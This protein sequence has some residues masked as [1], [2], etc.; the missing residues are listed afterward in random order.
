MLRKL[1]WQLPE[2][3]R[4]LGAGGAGALTDLVVLALCVEKLHLSP[5][6]GAVVGF[7]TGSVVGYVFYWAIVFPHVQERRHKRQFLLFLFTCVMG[8]L[9]TELG[10]YLFTILLHIHYIAVKILI[11][12]AVFFLSYGIRRRFI[13]RAG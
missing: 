8:L 12:F 6:V 2:W 11:T 10:L 7:L 1:F 13:F 5:L 3:F 9:A 4:A